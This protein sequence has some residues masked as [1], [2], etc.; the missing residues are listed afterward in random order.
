[1]VVELQDKP[2]ELLLALLESPNLTVSRQELYKR[3]WPTKT[4]GSFEEGLNTASRKL[5]QS[6]ND[7]AET[8]RIIKTVPKR[9]YRLIAKVEFVAPAN[10]PL[11]NSQDSSKRKSLRN[12]AIA[13]G[14]TLVIAAAVLVVVVQ[15]SRQRSR[16]LSPV[17]VPPLKHLSGDA[18]SGV[19]ADS[20]SAPSNTSHIAK[21]QEFY[22]QALTQGE[23]VNSA[24][25][26]FSS[27]A[28]NKAAIR[29]LQR[30]VA[31]D[32]GYSS[33]WAAL[34]R[35]YYYDSNSPDGGTTAKLRAKAALRRAVALD[36]GGIDAATDLINIEIEEG[37]LNKA[38][39]DVT[40]LLH[41]HPDSGAAHLVYAYVLWYAGLLDESARECEK[42]RSIDAGVDMAPCSYVFTALGRYDRAREFLQLR[43]GTEYEKAGYVEI[44]LRE[45]KQDEALQH[46]NSLPT[47]AFYGQQ[48]LKPCLQHR[49]TTEVNRAGQQVRSQLMAG[50]DGLGKYVLATWDSLC[51][52]PDRA[53]P[54]LRQAIAQNY[55]A[56]PQMETDPMLARVR[57]MQAFG[58]IR[59]LGIA[60]QQQFLEH[61]RKSSLE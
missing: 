41:Q 44:L 25:S 5:R 39:D 26:S 9:G 35:Y 20:S 24:S 56:Y 34:G 36:P 38:Y 57:A 52:Q 60:C 19:N 16:K 11:S 48:L 22:L 54:E 7:S 28:S 61:R 10:L 4:F 32:P 2:L 40:R 46:L 47:T 23:P 50:T 18:R 53:Y 45:G 43:S 27:D 55:C 12:V 51:E 29:L 30:A 17:V 15:L 3:L 31:L 21:S 33:A 13:V 37:E 8:P 6:L 59:S 14:V 42:S 49:P 58:E 1:M